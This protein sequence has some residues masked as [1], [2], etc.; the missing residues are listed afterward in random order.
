MKITSGNA[1]PE[2]QPPFPVFQIS[3]RGKRYLL[4]DANTI[5][6]LRK[7]HNI[8]GVLI[9][10][11]PQFPQQNTFLGLPLEFQPEEVRLLV[12]KKVVYILDD[13]QSHWNSLQSPP[14]S[15]EAFKSNLRNDALA[16]AA[17]AEKHKQHRTQDALQKLKACESV[18]DAS[19]LKNPYTD[20]KAAHTSETLFN[21][22]RSQR[23][24]ATS[25]EIASWTSTPTTSYPPLSAPH[26]SPSK[27]PD[28]NPAQYALFQHLH[29]YGYFISPGLRFGCQFLV[30]PGDPLRFHSHFLATSLEWDEK[31]DLLDL[32]G[33]GRLAT[34]VK[35]GWLLGGF[36]K[37][38]G[39]TQD[40]GAFPKNFSKGAE[41][42]TEAPRLRT[43]CIEW[44]GM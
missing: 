30:Y 19:Q 38:E 28:V 29:S 1:P 10:T 24:S 23:D 18:T 5:F 3:R 41:K 27:L 25:F 20:N 44:G 22:S 9:G 2:P 39:T 15:L 33:G 36:E 21:L 40:S 8:L 26:E 42:Q 4:Y 11:L 31:I 17:F 37:E 16:A 12:E 14:A 7:S 35:K 43:F 6:W 32:V 13:L 34:G